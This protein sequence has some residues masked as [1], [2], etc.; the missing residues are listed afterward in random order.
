MNAF[1]RFCA[2]H[3]PTPGRT[4]VAG[5]RVY[6]GREDRRLLYA[7]AVGVDMLDGPG[8]DFVADLEQPPPAEFVGAFQHI[9]CVSVL[10]HCRR[11]WLV[12][13]NFETLLAPGGTILISTPFCWRIHAYPNDY[14]RFSPAG[15]ESLFLRIK[16]AA[17][18]MGNERLQTKTRIPSVKVDGHPY[19]SRTETFGFGV[20]E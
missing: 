9:D 1:E 11:P 19:M 8:V 15:I 13:I 20:R 2:Q 5:S 17:L 12:A 6:P 16:W 4:L 18:A 3:E 14:F 7:D 10:E